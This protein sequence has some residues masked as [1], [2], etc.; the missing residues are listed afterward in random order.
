LGRTEGR[1]RPSYPPHPFFRRDGCGA[2]EEA[3][4]GRMLSRSVGCLLHP[5]VLF[6]KGTRQ[7]RGLKM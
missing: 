7:R 1:R 5:L 3:K 2:R 4:Q 6:C